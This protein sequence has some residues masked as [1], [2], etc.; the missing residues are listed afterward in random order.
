V[1]VLRYGKRSRRVPLGVS[2]RVTLTETGTLEL[3]CRS[4]TSDHSW[5]LA[6][7]LRGA[8][9]D[10]LAID[11]DAQ[12]DDQESADQVVVEATAIDSAAALVRRT[13]GDRSLDPLAPDTLVAEMETAIGFGKQA[14]P[15]AV[16]RQLADVLLEVSVGRTRTAAHESRWLNLTGFCV[17]PGFGAAADVGRISE[18]RKVY[19]AG[20]SFPKDVQGQV[21]WLVLW[22]RAAGGFTAGHQR[23]LA[24][25]VSGQLGLS[26]K[27]PP[28]L[29]PQIEREAWRLLGGL[30]RLDA[31]QR[32]K[33][34]DALADRL[35]RDSRNASFLW[36]MS[37]LGS[38]TPLYGPLSSVVLPATAER[39]LGRLLAKSSGHDS[40]DAIV[41]IGALTGDQARDISEGM[42]TRILETLRAAGVDE[43]RLR[44]L[45]EVVAPKRADQSR[46][47]GEALPEGLKLEA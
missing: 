2:L 11:S 3:W 7:N 44:P 39:W 8:E 37:R 10:P 21:E 9:S 13:F 34:G 31:G 12:E 14:W 22:Q 5:R 41:Q 23:E 20:L 36:A 1:T 24:Q 6:F 29:N 35:R 19:A 26:E 45:T 18:L 28:R 27:K 43:E 16:I 33:L 32:A 42:R 40:V 15:L 38:R 25:R 47:F 4:R 30:E 17:R 46:V